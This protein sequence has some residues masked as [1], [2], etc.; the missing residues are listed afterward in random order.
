MIKL[1][2]IKIF[3]KIILIALLNIEFAQAITINSEDQ[4]NGSAV[5]AWTFCLT[6]EL[7]A[8]AAKEK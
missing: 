8:E 2:Q 1:K 4:K 3:L 5:C 7:I 6:E